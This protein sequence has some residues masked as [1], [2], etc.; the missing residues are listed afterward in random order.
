MIIAMCS[1]TSFLGPR[2]HGERGGGGGA[3]HRHLECDGQPG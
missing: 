3:G 2:A 1:Y